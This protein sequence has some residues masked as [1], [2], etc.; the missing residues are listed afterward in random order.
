M[1]SLLSSV[2]AQLHGGTREWLVHDHLLGNHVGVDYS[3]GANCRA[4]CDPI[5][6]WRDRSGFINTT[7]ER[8]SEQQIVAV[9]TFGCAI[10]TVGGNSPATDE[11]TSIY[12]HHPSR[13]RFGMLFESPRRDN[14]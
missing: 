11:Q 3:N 8:S 12:H 10:I 14:R 5:R 9:M 1:R 13:A 7:S 2:R 4:C 6:S